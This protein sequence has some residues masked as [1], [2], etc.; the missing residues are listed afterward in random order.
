MVL[1]KKY[2]NEAINTSQIN[3]PSKKGSG[4]IFLV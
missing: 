1:G 4:L 2:Q 3:E